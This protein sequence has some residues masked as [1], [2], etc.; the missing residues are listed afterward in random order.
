[1]GGTRF[2]DAQV[3]EVH[4]GDDLVLMVNLGIDGLFKRVRARLHGVDTPNAFR[5]KTDTE[6]GEVRDEV[7]RLTAGRCKIEVIVQSK[8][9]W[10]VQLYAE[11]DGQQVCVNEVLKSRGYVYRGKDIQK[12]I[13]GTK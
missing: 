12:D 7:K 4:S 6:A 2:Y 10:L 13:E 5:A 3:E 11:R 9:G 1:M 8:G